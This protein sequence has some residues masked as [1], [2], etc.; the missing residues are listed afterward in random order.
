M[1]KENNNTA[2]AGFCAG[3]VIKKAK[4]KPQFQKVTD[5]SR[6]PIRGLWKRGKRFYARVSFADNNGS[7]VD[8]RIPLKA[9]SVPEARLE[10]GLVKSNSILL[11]SDIMVEVT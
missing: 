10:Y 6:R 9:K 4:T 5:H 7:N 3:N 2:C 8:R 11:T 1:K